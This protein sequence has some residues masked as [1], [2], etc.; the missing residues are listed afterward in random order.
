MA[1]TFHFKQFA[2]EHDKSTMKVGT[3]AVL[4]GAWANV[5]HAGPILEIGTGCGI[6]SLML[7]QRFN[8]LVTA[9]D[10]DFLSVQQAIAN[11]VSS[12]WHQKI[13]VIHTSL[14]EFTNSQPGLFDAVVCNPPFFNQSLKA[15]TYRKNLA[16]HNDNLPPEELFNA[17]NQ[18]LSPEG[19]F[20]VIAPIEIFS[21]FEQK[22]LLN[23]FV[24]TRKTEIIPKEGKRTSRVLLEFSKKKRVSTENHLT[25]LTIDDKYTNE[26]I[27]LTKD[28]YL[29]LHS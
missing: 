13:T 2:V 16:R 24:T 29:F 28:F 19:L 6:I 4:L 18:L 8:A 27:S 9:I 1:T 15:S 23:N 26:Y 20:S 3:D 25:I 14:Q 7:A 22:A 12:K 10:I 5:S 17:V 11:V 21:L